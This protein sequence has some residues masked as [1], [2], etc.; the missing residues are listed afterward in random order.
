MTDKPKL[1][2]AKQGLTVIEMVDDG[3]MV[4]HPDGTL[5]L[6]NSPA[7]AERIANKW[8]RENIPAGADGSI[9]EIDWRGV[10]PPKKRRTK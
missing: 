4:M 2:L 6:A 5:N 9:G 3:I 7:H 1:N 8:L 10:T